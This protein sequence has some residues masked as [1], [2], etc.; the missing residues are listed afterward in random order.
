M[1]LYVCLH[2]HGGQRTSLGVSI[3]KTTF[4]EIV[5][6]LIR[7]DRVANELNILPSLC[8]KGLNSTSC[9]GGK[10]SYLLSHCPSPTILGEPHLLVSY[11]EKFHGSVLSHWRAWV[12]LSRIVDL[13]CGLFHSFTIVIIA[14]KCTFFFSLETKT[15]TLDFKK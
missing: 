13:L 7:P 3:R 12:R 15:K 5:S 10:C 2:A 6:T 14:L 1:Y 4:S 8:A 11:F 9:L